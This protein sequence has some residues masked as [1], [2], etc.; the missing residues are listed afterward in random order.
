M[1]VPTLAMIWESGEDTDISFVYKAGATGS[2]QPVDLSTNYAVRMD[3]RSNDANSTLLYTFN[4]EDVTEV[5]SVDQIGSADNEIILGSDGSINLPVPRALTLP[6]GSVYEYM[7]TNNLNS[8]VFDVILRNKST[9]K[10]KKILSG[11]I[12]VNKTV[13]RWA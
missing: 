13:T 2:E 7:K 12:A 6:G 5:P 9:N 8:F 4:S 1:A 10:Q 3:V 11:T